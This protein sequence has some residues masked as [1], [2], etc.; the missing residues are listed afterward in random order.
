[1]RIWRAGYR[2]IA[3]TGLVFKAAPYAAPYAVPYATPVQLTQI[4]HDGIIPS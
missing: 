1:M 4:C 2:L 3:L